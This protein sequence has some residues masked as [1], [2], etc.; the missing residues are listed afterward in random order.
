MTMH[1]VF[2][3]LKLDMLPVALLPVFWPHHNYLNWACFRRVM[4]R[5]S[6]YIYELKC[7]SA[8]SAQSDHPFC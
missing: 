7:V 1:D 4:K 2:E 3:R 5:L 8:Q 6:S